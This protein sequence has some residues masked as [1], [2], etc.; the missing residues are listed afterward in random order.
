MLKPE[1]N[2]GDG[3]FELAAPIYARVKGQPELVKKQYLDMN[4]WLLATFCSR[5]TRCAWHTH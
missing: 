3:A 2:T 4:M 1:Y 5:P